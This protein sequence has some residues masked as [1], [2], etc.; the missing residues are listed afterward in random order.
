MTR[1]LRRL[2]LPLW[3]TLTVALFADRNGCPGS[4][5]H[6]HGTGR[7]G[8]AEPRDESGHQE[9]SRGLL[10]TVVAVAGLVFVFKAMNFIFPIVGVPTP[11]SPTSSVSS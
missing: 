1:T 2:R 6:G 10:F 11:T 3:T 8:D 9:H 7:G 4:S 5:G